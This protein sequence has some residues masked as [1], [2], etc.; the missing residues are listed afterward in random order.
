ME[1]K[2]LLYKN[3]AIDNDGNIY[4]DLSQASFDFKDNDPGTITYL[5]ERYNGRPDLLAIDFLDDGAYV[6]S[7]LK[8]NGIF[9]SFSVGEGEIL[10]IPVSPKDN[11]SSFYAYPQIIKPL[12]INGTSKSTG[13][14]PDQSTVDPERLSRI[15]QIASKQPNGVSTPLPPNQLQPG[16]KSKT[17][18]DSGY[19]AMG[20]NLPTRLVNT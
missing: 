8:V 9:N 13:N 14:S 11:E 4:Y 6:D 10:F 2:S 19:I 5:S 20:T 18:L 7:I 15:S 16:D 17:E 1:I 12:E 3:E